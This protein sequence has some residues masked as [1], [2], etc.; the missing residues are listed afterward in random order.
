[1]KKMDFNKIKSLEIKKTSII[2]FV[3]IKFTNI[4]EQNI[5]LKNK[6]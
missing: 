5:N 1:M 6:R 4:F 3:A 2:F